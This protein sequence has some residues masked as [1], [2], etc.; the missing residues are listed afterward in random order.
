M[1]ADIWKVTHLKLMYKYSN[2]NRP[3]PIFRGTTSGFFAQC[4]HDRQPAVTG[5]SPGRAVHMELAH[6]CAL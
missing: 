5:V 2:R 3:L 4:K 6:V 1:R